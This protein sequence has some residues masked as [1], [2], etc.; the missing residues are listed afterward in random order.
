[1][2]KLEMGQGDETPIVDSLKRS[3]H[4]DNMGRDMIYYFPG[5]QLTEE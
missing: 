1:M 4:V 2:T 5:H 3:V